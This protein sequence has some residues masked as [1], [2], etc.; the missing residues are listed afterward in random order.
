[1]R[2]GSTQGTAAAD[3]SI[4]PAA[5]VAGSPAA[6]LDQTCRGLSGTLAGIV[7]RHMPEGGAY[8]LAA[9]WPGQAAGLHLLPLSER[10]LAAREM[11]LHDAG[12]ALVVAVPLP[13]GPSSSGPLAGVLVLEAETAVLSAADIIAAATVAARYLNQIVMG[14]L[15]AGEDAAGAQLRRQGE[16]LRVVCGPA[17]FPHAA[18]DTVNWLASQFDCTRVGLGMLRKGRIVL[19]ALSHSAWF[20]RKSHAV[21]AMESA[22]DEAC[23]QR[24][25]VVLPPVPG[26][27]PALAIAHRAA[28]GGMSVCSVVL[29]GGDGLGAG[30]LYF[31]RAPGRGFS[32]AEVQV[33]EQ[34]GQSAGPV[35]EAKDQ[36]YRWLGGRTRLAR[37]RLLAHLRDPRRPA[38]RAGLALGAVALAALTLLDATWR[39]GADAA[40]EG[41]QQRAIPA[42]FDGYLASA[43]VKAGLVVRKGQALAELDTRQI[44]L[45]AQRW[46]AEAAQHESRYRDAMARHDRPAGALAQAQ[47]QQAQ[48]QLMLAQD[49]LAQAALTAPFDAYVVSGDLTQRI[50]MPV[51]QG[52]TLFELAPLDAYRVIVKVDER[53]VR[54]VQ[55]GQRGEL[56]LS[57]MPGQRLAFRVTNIA[58]AEAADGRNAFRVEARLEQAA[59]ALRPGMQGVAKIEAGQ[60]SL[61]WIWT[62]SAWHWLQLQLWKWRP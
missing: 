4:K 48:A 22:M 13:A 59:P 8:V 52:K 28:A 36:A 18:L 7:V 41:E 44:R 34:I 10:C 47:A 50:G 45:E 60:R 11:V 23:D 6:W 37:A 5:W 35:L 39:V 31:E 61:L 1:M 27:R 21:A 51:E 49:R 32:L 54:A 57:G 17:V 29:A 43:A 58:A 24:R 62:H 19:Q 2:T 16:L 26:L 9:A 15:G 56:V 53:D 55:P 33:L 25:S 40:I 12:G 14:N 46:Q 3:G 42:P 30:V 38:L 20:E